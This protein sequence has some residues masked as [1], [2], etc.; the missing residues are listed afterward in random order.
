MAELVPQRGSTR[1]A[2]CFGVPYS[3]HSSFRELTMFCCALRIEKIIPTVN[4]GSAASR[5]KMKAWIDR[6]LSERRKNGVVKI[7]QGAG[8]VEW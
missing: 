6:W 4:V 7:G 3:E 8:M 5:A 2:S 1:E